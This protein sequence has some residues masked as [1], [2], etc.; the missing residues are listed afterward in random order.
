MQD[1]LI[2]LKQADLRGEFADLKMPVV[3]I[4]GQLDT[5]IPVAVAGK[6]QELLPEI[7]LTVIDRAGHLPF[8]A[9]QDAVVKTI[10]HFMDMK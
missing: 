9:H 1:G 7:D 4:L 3:V 10:C 5:L 2:I 8:L 6:M